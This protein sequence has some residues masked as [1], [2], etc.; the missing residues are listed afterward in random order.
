MSI[1]PE[2]ADNEL[3]QE[4]YGEDHQAIDDSTQLQPNAQTAVSVNRY[5]SE[6]DSESEPTPLQT[7]QEE[8][9]RLNQFI[10]RVFTPNQISTIFQRSNPVDQA[11]AEGIPVNN[12]TNIARYK[13]VRRSFLIERAKR[14]DEF[15]MEKLCL[16][17][18][19][20]IKNNVRTCIEHMEADD[21]IGK[22][23]YE[24][25]YLF[26]AG[27]EVVPWVVDRF[28]TSGNSFFPA[29]LGKRIWGALVDHLRSKES[30][31]DLSRSKFSSLKDAIKDAKKSDHPETALKDNL[32]Q[33][34]EDGF[35]EAPAYIVDGQINS[36]NLSYDQ[37]IEELD[38][39]SPIFVSPIDIE[40]EV[41]KSEGNEKLIATINQ[42]SD[43]ER[44]VI[45]HYYG[46][47][48]LEPQTFIQVGQK[49]GLTESRVS[50]IHTKAK[51]NITKLIAGEPIFYRPTELSVLPDFSRWRVPQA[52]LI[53]RIMTKLDKYKDKTMF[54]Q[55]V[56]KV[57]AIIP[58]LDVT[59]TYSGI[60]KL[61]MIT[62]EVPQDF[63]LSQVRQH[64][65]ATWLAYTSEHSLT[66]EITNATGKDLQTVLEVEA[67]IKQLIQP[68]ANL[69]VT[70]VLNKSEAKVFGMVFK[71]NAEIA[72]ELTITESTVRTHKHNIY[73]RFGLK[74]AVELARFMDENGLVDWDTL[75]EKMSL[76][77]LSSTERELVKRF[78]GSTY[79]EAAL[80]LNKSVA[81][82][83]THWH[84]TYAKTKTVNRVQLALLAIRKGLIEPEPIEEV[85]EAA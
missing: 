39:D 81:T 16:S 19:N 83:R 29:F 51:A 2:A 4:V 30:G 31:Q 60:D 20:A 50:Q 75:P 58:E 46:F 47:F 36:V 15:A 22:V 25:D 54:D 53:S 59:H 38:E 42:L 74:K 24:A 44:F 8:Q 21:A 65:P 40:S 43:R 70:S 57:I 71:T 7:G 14:G 55:D 82:I 64:L 63:S 17:A 23:P 27:L 48:E 62:R 85:K 5:S 1:N 10:S 9:V 45:A 3:V 52:T 72:T 13:V 67:A 76:D 37:L 79:K 6:G 69:D 84:N 26:Q 41:I 66:L 77:G 73:K 28:D 56:D 68:E 78:C 34:V 12:L 18:I 35:I 32:Q 80:A 11:Q 61:A 33:L 49:L